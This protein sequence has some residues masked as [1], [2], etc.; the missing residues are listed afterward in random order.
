MDPIIPLGTSR[1]PRDTSHTF[2]ASC[3]RLPIRPVKDCT[4]L[5]VCWGQ[6]AELRPGE[7]YKGREKAGKTLKEMIKEEKKY[8]M[9]IHCSFHWSFAVMDN[10]KK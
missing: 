7:I 2:P 1:T 4:I 6:Y 3:L 5:D 10:K 9:I 8:I